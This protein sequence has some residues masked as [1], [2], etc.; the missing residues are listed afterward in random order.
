M[1]DGCHSVSTCQARGLAG[2]CSLHH[3]RSHRFLVWFRSRKFYRHYF[4]SSKVSNGPGGA[5]RFTCLVCGSGDHDSQET[6]SVNPGPRPGVRPPQHPAP[7]VPGPR[8]PQR[9]GSSRGGLAGAEAS[10]RFR[11]TAWPSRGPCRVE[12][13][14]G[15]PRHIS[16][17]ACTSEISVGLGLPSPAAAG[18]EQGGLPSAGPGTHEA[19]GLA[20]L[21]SA[22]IPS[23]SQRPVHG[24]VKC[25][26]NSS[27]CKMTKME[28][29]ASLPVL[30]RRSS[31]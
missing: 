31:A 27:R 7:Y 8:D 25:F 3:P 20:G 2:V 29:P 16:S 4:V 23:P 10:M 6:S 21:P 1:C 12:T 15:R 28:G 26:S 13:K 11:G 9:S 22:P 14:V 18:V 19:D 5:C 24:E 17:G 30:R